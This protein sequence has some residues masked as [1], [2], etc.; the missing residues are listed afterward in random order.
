RFEESQKVKIV[1]KT[2]ARP[3][4]VRVPEATP[5]APPAAVVQPPT[6]PPSWQPPPEPPRRP[7]PTPV[8]APEIADPR[9]EKLYREAGEARVAG[10]MGKAIVKLEEAAMQSPESPSIRYELGLV[11]EQMGVYDTATSHYQKIFEMGISQAGKYYE[12][13]AK[14]LR[15]GFDKPD[16]MLGK[17]SLG[18]VRIFKNPNYESGE[19]VVL[20]IPVQKAPTEEIDI[21][22]LAVSVMF[23]NR[24]SKGEIV[25]LEDNSWV[26]QFWNTLPF[27][28]VGG[29][30]SL[31]MIYT[32]PKAGG[33]GD[34]LFGAVTYYGQTVSLIYKGETM[35]VQAWPS[36]L[37]ARMPRGGPSDGGSMPPEFQDTLP[38]DFNPDAPLLPPLPEN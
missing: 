7:D 16:A 26:N 19:Q 36:D 38:P 1:E 10:D 8:S 35:A 32:I 27:D 18:R 15:D 3:V 25:Q 29:E 33:V 28:W 5:V 24:N 4:V 11:H 31:R 22:E 12:L 23:F 20:T 37:Y 14:K 13:A 30:E 21:S 2:V 9:A 6:P 34:P 17:L